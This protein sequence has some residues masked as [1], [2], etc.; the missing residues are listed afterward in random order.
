MRWPTGRTFR[1]SDPGNC[2]LAAGDWLIQ[3]VSRLED[4][5]AAG[6]FLGIKE[7]KFI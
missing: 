2:P 4:I 7:K 6:D 1:T 5:I 3:D